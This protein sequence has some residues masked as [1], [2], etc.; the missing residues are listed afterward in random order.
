MTPADSPPQ[1]EYPYASRSADR[2]LAEPLPK[3]PI[4]LP[5]GPTWLALVGVTV[6]FLAANFIVVPLTEVF[7]QN[8]LGAVLV[9]YCL[10]ISAA[11]GF[12]LAAWLVWGGGSFLSRLTLH[13]G[14]VA[15]LGAAWLIG[16]ILAEGPRDGDIRDAL[17]VVPFSLPLFSLA[18]Q[19]PLWVARHCF[20]WRLVDTCSDN[21]PPRPLAIRDLMAGTV[22]VALS[23]ALARL[24]EGMDE[25]GW[26]VWA[27][28][29][30]SVAGICLVSVLPVAYW[31]LR[32]KSLAI[33][34]VCVPVQAAVAIFITLIVLLIFDA[35]MRLEEFFQFAVVVVSFATTLT[36]AA[37]AAR[38]AGFRLE[39]GRGST[40]NSH[41]PAATSN[42]LH[43]PA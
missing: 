20:G 14:A 6:V 32:A 1:L 25:E 7:D 29:G 2:P 17:E 35:R 40:V 23:F 41:L 38:L 24:A 18:I 42:P 19:V 21:V 16:A 4:P 22:I 9:F 27:I 10:G 36:A 43:E 13:W 12:V 15:A 37:L 39:I 33:G 11:E 34:L 31:M 5:I 26:L 8:D 28:L 30:L 3:A